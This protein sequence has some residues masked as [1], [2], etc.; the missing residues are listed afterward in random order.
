[1]DNGP[2]KA[3]DGECICFWRLSPSVWKFYCT[4]LKPDLYIVINPLYPR[5]YDGQFADD[6][7]KMQFPH[8]KIPYFDLNIIE[9]CYNWKRV[10]IGWGNGLVPD[11]GHAITW[12]AAD[13]VYWRIYAPLGDNEYMMTSSLKWNHL[14]VNSPHKGQWR[15]ALMFSL[16]CTWINDSVSNRHA[17]DLR[18][19]RAHCE[20]IVME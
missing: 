13:Q 9:V 14:P 16:I 18:R 2:T 4:L 20:V 17:G 19:H 6:I 1:M 7:F 11:R 15:E 12:T 8:W 3:I 10:S 5:Q